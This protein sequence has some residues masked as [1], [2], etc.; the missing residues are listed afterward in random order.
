MPGKE[1]GCSKMPLERG[2]RIRNL[3]W[4]LDCH[5]LLWIGISFSDWTGALT[6]DILVM[7]QALS[8]FYFP[9]RG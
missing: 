7:E 3:R 6:D 5:V 1:V 9:Q 4:Q 2:K 8:P